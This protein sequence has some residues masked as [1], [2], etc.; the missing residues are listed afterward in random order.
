[1]AEDGGGGGA[2]GGETSSSSA[3]STA[4]GKKKKTDKFYAENWEQVGSEFCYT[5]TDEDVG[6]VLKVRCFPVADDLDHF[7]ELVSPVVV[8]RLPLEADEVFPFEKRQK[9]TTEL[10]DAENDEFRVMTYNL[11]ADYY[12]DS[13]FS[14]TSL[15]AYCPAEWLHGE[16]RRQVLLKEIPGYHPDVILMQEV[17]RKMFRNG[18]VSVLGKHGMT[19]ALALKKEVPEGLATFW[20]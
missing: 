9:L 17:D 7:V 14:R 12:A 20:R 2:A 3:A 11:L 10:C 8:S 16:Y 19:G 6:R 18:L 5:P 15:F 1:M 4:G 13:D